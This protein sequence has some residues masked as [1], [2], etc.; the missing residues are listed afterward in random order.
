MTQNENSATG[1]AIKGPRGLDIRSVSPT[2]Q[3][4]MIN[5]LYTE[6]QIGVTNGVQPGIIEQAFEAQAKTR[7]A[8]LVMVQIEVLGR[9]RI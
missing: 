8:E 2:L 1:Y 6:C 3:A 7:R 9:G 5:W 4:A